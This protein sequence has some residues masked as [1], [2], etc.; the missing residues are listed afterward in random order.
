VLIGRN[1]ITGAAAIV[2][3]DVNNDSIYFG[4]PVKKQRDL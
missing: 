4:T 2:L 1:S 3:G